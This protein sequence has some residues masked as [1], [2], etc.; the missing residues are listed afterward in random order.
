MAF[1]DIELNASKIEKMGTSRLEAIVS[2]YCLP[3][4]LDGCG[5]F[6]DSIA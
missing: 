6:H 2:P 1:I 3:N 5:I 4:G